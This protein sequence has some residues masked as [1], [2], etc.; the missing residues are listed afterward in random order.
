MACKRIKHKCSSQNKC[1]EKV[2]KTNFENIAK[3]KKVAN[4]K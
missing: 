4:A 1:N 2:K 3:H